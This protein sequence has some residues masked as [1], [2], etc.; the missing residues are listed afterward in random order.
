MTV[1]SDG[2]VMPCCYASKPLGNLNEAS[3]EEIW[4]GRAAVQLR[5]FIKR[6]EIHPICDGAVCKFVLNMKAA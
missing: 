4:N 2:R 6:N 3:A 5:E 1:A